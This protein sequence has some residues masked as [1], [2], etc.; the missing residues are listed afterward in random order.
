MSYA[1]R[2]PSLLAQAGLGPMG[3][4][5]GDKI[6]ANVQQQRHQRRRPPPKPC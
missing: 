6:A 5:L 2:L 3:Q 4:Q 1:D